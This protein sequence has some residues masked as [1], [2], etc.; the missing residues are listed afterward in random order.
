MKILISILFILIYALALCQEGEWKLKR[1][2]DGVAVYTRKLDDSQILEYKVL[3]TINTD[4][5][6]F[7]EII[8]NTN[9]YIKWQ[10][11]LESA[12]TLLVIN[13]YEFYNYITADMPWPIE[14]RDMVVHVKYE[15][16]YEKGE[17]FAYSETIPD[18]IKFSKD[19]KRLTNGKG[20]WV[21]KQVD[22]YLQVMYTFAGDP[23]LPVPAFIINMFLVEGPFI[24]FCNLKEFALEKQN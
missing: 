23:G 11:N 9:E 24:T 16:D 18:Y 22:D 14:D 3:T 7:I 8:T 21:I 2:K 17:C 20:K 19:Y 6:S 10:K 4:L 13:K 12:S 1:N 15:V 5:K